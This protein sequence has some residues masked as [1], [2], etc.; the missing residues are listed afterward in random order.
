VWCR[1]RGPWRC[2][3]VHEPERLPLSREASQHRLR[4]RPRLDELDRDERLDRLALFGYPD[5]A[6]AAVAD[7]LEELVAS[8]DDGADERGR[9]CVRCR[10]ARVTL[11][12]PDE[13]L[14]GSGMSIEEKFQPLQ[15]KSC[16]RA[17]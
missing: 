1:R 9:R 14:A 7:L 5:G 12:R 13:Q 8:S 4:V 17:S 10:G 15:F 2:S 6:H 16:Q 11:V 3:G